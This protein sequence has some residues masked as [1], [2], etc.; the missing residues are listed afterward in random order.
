VALVVDTQPPTVAPTLRA[1]PEDLRG[2]SGGEVRTVPRPTVIGV[3]E[4]GTF[5][6]LLRVD[7]ENTDHVMSLLG[8]TATAAD[9]SFALPLEV[10]LTAVPV[11]VRGRLRDAAGNL[12]PAGPVLVLRAAPAAADLSGDLRAGIRLERPGT[13]RGFALGVAGTGTAPARAGGTGP[14][15]LSLGTVLAGAGSADRGLPRPA[16]VELNATV[17]TGRRLPPVR[18]PRSAAAVPVPA[19]HDGGGRTGF[20]RTRPATGAS[21]VGLGVGG[22]R[23]RSGSGGLPADLLVLAR[24][25]SRRV[26]GAWA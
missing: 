10:A 1:R 16:T 25:D 4:P 13:G 9:G 2:G 6:D 19:V 5:F 12:G 14:D 23:K 17:R 11:A 15:D 20:V 26:R 7:S 3:G 18:W 22:G 8:M 21:L 24:D